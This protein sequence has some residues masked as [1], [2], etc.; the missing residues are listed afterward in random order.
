MNSEKRGLLVAI[1]GGDGSGKATQAELTRKHIDEQ[2]GRAVL[3]VSFPRYGQKSAVF[4]ENYLNGE[5]G[6]IN[7]LPPDVVALLFATDRM[8]GTPEIKQWLYDNPE[9][10]AVLD[11]YIGSNL[12]HQG[13]KILDKTERHQFYEVIQNYETSVLGMLQPD[14]NIVLVLPASVAQTNI[15][16]KDA[17]AYTDKKRDIHEADAEYLERV[18]KCYEELCEIYPE[19]YQ[20]ISCL[21]EMGQMRTRETI[22]QDI[23]QIIAPYL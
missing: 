23:H 8:A 6:G 11:R 5:Y 2:L 16:K 4:V 1:E 17:R 19:R 18:K 9:G 15:D 20:L 14:K 7:D 22:Q 10:V 13:A 21:D 12:A 3:K